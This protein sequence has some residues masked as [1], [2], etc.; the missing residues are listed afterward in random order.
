MKK[1]LLITLS[2]FINYISY[3]QITLFGDG[4]F[5]IGSN[6]LKFNTLIAPPS[7]YNVLVHGLTD[8][9]VYQIPLASIGGT[10]LYSGDGTLAGNRTVTGS[11]NSLTFDGL[12]NFRVNA[13]TFLLAKSTPGA[14]YTTAVIGTP[15]T[16]QLGYT[17]VATVY[18]KGSGV[19]IDTNNNVGIGTQMSTSAPLY[20]TG[21]SAYINGMQSAA[22]NYYKIENVTSNVS[23]DLQDYFFVIDATSSNLTI[24]LPAASTAFGAGVGIQYVFKRIDNSGN[25]VQIVRNG[26]DTIDGSTSV[27]LSVQYESKELQ[28]VSSS[29]WA[30]K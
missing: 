10:T 9:A 19:I 3:S 5:N 25:T 4:A 22:G 20:A 16:W 2:F 30:I 1:I 12:F 29:A 28:C 13:N 24:T 26:S 21:L 17:P 27:S 18:S 15:N 7:T 6:K 11:N 23:A 8:S 14:V